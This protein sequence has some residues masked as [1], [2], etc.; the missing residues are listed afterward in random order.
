[1]DEEAHH[2]TRR[3][4]L[5]R[6]VIGYAQGLALFALYHWRKQ[7]DPVAFAALMAVGWLAPITLLG[8]LGAAR[9]R[10]VIL[11]TA[12]A[13]AIAAVLGGY[14]AFVR[15]KDA[16]LVLNP[17][18]GDGPTLIFTAAA[19]YILH[20]LIVPADA[21]RR[22][23][24][25]YQRYF[26]EGWMDAVR[27]A[28]SALFVGVL[29]LL[30][31]LGAAL[32]KLIGISFLQELI[33]KDWFAFPA[34]T[35][36]FALAVHL[37]DVRVALVRGARTL[38]LTLLSWLLT[39][40]TVIAMAFLAALPFTGLASL[41][42]AGSSSGVMLTVCA[43]LVILLN[44]TYQ[45]GERDGQPPTVLKWFARV[46]A[47]ALAPLVAVAAYGLSVR[48][49]QH[50]LTPQRI[51][52]AA[53]LIVAASY[54]VGY[55]GAALGRG[56]WMARLETT[57]WLTA[58]LVVA[59]ILAL[60]SPIL[61]PVR[62]SVGSQVARLE[63]G[64]VA[65]AQFDF[66]FLRFKSGRWGREALAK[67]AS[68]HGDARRQEIARLAAA[69]RASTNPYAP[70]PIPASERAEALHPV[71]PLPPGFVDQA[72]SNVD[73]PALGCRAPRG[74]CVTLMADIDGQPGAEVI[75]L[76]P[77]LARVYGLADGRW[78]QIG[79]LTHLCSGDLDAVRQGQVRVTPAQPR[80]DLEIAGRR[81]GFTDDQPCPAVK[82]V[83]YQTDVTDVELVEPV[84]PPKPAAKAK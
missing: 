30:L 48:I 29:W 12:G 54:A 39:V 64:A 73:D 83:V 9:R 17:W 4:L 45:E 1:M 72:W 13:A 28:L 60:F 34:T 21:E 8:V 41:R 56:R 33:Q 61:D 69:V 51:Y 11:W 38:L 70:P 78:R 66:M 44:A 42:A 32:F 46:A 49:G 19:I 71:A 14:G 40:I 15:L 77:Y 68:A 57:N 63:A 59:V 5:S 37:T 65:P 43:A 24:A 31:W 79:T 22:W 50:G 75:V 35:T 16:P 27:L 76:L 67:L 62:L 3:L 2:P 74:T 18:G 26:D 80:N 10:T 7:V 82:G 25:T 20:H 55:F 52:F 6:A 81:H 84:P 47:V 36:F 53:C 58:Q 23:R